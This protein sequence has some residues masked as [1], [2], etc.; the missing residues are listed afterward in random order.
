[1]IYSRNKF[2]LIAPIVKGLKAMPVL[3]N[4][5]LCLSYNKISDIS[6]LDDALKELKNI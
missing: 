1:M 5:E 6:C 4:L 2:S 3:K